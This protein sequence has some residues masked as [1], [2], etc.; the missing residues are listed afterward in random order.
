MS[1]LLVP[2]APLS[3]TKTRLRDCFSKTQLKDLT[4]AMFKDLGQKLMKVNNIFN[5]KIVYCNNSEIL[6]LTDDY[7]LTGIKEELTSPLKSF[8]QVIT[9]LNTIA[10][11][12]FDAQQTVIN[13][14]DLILIS[15]KNFYD[16]SS[17][18]KKNSIVICPAI[19]SAGISIFGR[20]PPEIISSS[21]FSD[22][23]ESSLISLYKKA[24]EKGLKITVYD[25]F[26]GGFDVDLKQDL[27]LA[28]KYL[29]LLNLKQTE[30]YSFLKKNLKLTFQKDNRSN[31][32]DFKIINK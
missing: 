16:I 14:L 1:V 17:L 28:Y 5:E 3:H 10:V 25:S 11:K 12:K 15:L 21:C 31:N 7:G 8:D 26:R 9:D 13:F 30:T 29:K 20:N 6:E 4:I 27:V 19:H 2:I 18:L 22:P 23:N 32:R 24:N